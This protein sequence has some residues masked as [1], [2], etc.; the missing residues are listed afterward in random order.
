MKYMKCCLNWKVIAGLAVAGLAV[1]AIEPDLIGRALPALVGL[2]CPL[3]MIAM[4]VGM[5][6]MSRKPRADGAAGSQ[7]R[8]AMSRNERL[9]QLQQE[10]RQ[11]QAELAAVAAELQDRNGSPKVHGK[12]GLPL[13]D[14]SLPS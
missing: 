4:M 14:A 5:G 8:L 1:W 11:V 13:A 3:S 2:I 10:Q 7:T 12:G 9:Q 6:A